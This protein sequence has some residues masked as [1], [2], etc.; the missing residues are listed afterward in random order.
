MTKS[1][2]KNLDTV[3]PS[4]RVIKTADTPN[5]S[6]TSE[7]CYQL[8][9]Y[10]DEEL[11]IRILT[12]EGGGYFSMEWVAINDLLAILENWDANKGITSVALAPLFRGKSVNTPAF[13][14]AALRAEGII[15]PLEGKKRN[16]GLS[17]I[18][19]FLERA[20]QLQAGK[21]PV[22]TTAKKKAPAKT[23]AAAK[24]PRGSKK[25]TPK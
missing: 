12:S 5:I 17:D 15:Q 16:F 4:V 23:K 19:G 3:V 7:I 18:S 21:T 1:T 13:L 6:G 8:G 11:A 22:R 20:R 25:P 9:V 14:M 24:A 10:P 2:R